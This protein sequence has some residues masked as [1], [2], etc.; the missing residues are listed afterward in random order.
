MEFKSVFLDLPYSSKTP[1]LINKIRESSFIFKAY[2]INSK[3]DDIFY[4]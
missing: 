1:A 4:F 2:F 3:N